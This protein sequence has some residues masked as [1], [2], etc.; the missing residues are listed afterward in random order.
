[1]YNKVLALAPHTDDIELGCGGLLS[2]L[3][4]ENSNIEIHAISFSSAQ[5]LSIGDPVEEF[6]SAM[7]ILDIDGEF[8]DFTPRV[9][10]QQRQD[11]LDY[12]WNRNQDNEYDLVLCPSSYDNHQDHQVIE[13]ECFRAFKKTSIFG[14][15]MPWNNRTFSTDIF[16]KLSKVDVDTK[17][18]MVDCYKTQGER[19]FMSK[20]Y[21]FDMARTRG[22]QLGCEYVEC[23]EA[24]RVVI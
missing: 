14:Y 8:L 10:H 9:F 4:K 22:L 24:I 18:Q 2:K 5:P 20:E 15:E 19:V 1:M 17:Y 16:V 12:L 13:Q 21:I 6:K 23:Y 11:I 3:K 7:S